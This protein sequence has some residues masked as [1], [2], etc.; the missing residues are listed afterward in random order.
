MFG[1]RVQCLGFPIYGLWFEAQF[2]IQ[3]FGFRVLGSGFRAQG[4][5]FRG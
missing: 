3:Q 4:S 5:R 2:R 1:F